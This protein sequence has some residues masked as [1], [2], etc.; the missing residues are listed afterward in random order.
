MRQI[1]VV[2]YYF[3]P[4]G[5]SGVQRIAGFVRRLPDYGWQPTVLT[6][7]PGGYYAYDDSLWSKVQDAAI[8]VEQ[9]RSLDPTRLFRS[10]TTVKFP[11]QSNQKVLGS[12][13]HWL[14]LPDNKVGWLPFAVRAGLRMGANQKFDAVL[15]SAPPYTGHLIGKMLSRKWN[16][17]LITDFR[18]DWVENPRHTYP[19]GIHRSLHVRLERQVLSHSSAVI[20]I[21]RPILD[22]INQRHP[23]IQTRGHVISH[24]YDQDRS[25]NERPVD[26]GQEL[27]F[28]YTGIFYDAQ[29]PEYF[30]RGLSKFLTDNPTMRGKTSAIFAGLVPNQFLHW[31]KT[32]NLND[33]VQYRGYLP[34]SSVVNL[35]KEADVLWMTI[36]NRSGSAGISTGKLFEYMGTQKP[37]LALVPAGTAR[38]T[39]DRYGAA[40]IADPEHEDEIAQVMNQIKG[41]WFSRSFPNPNDSFLSQFNRDQLTQKLSGILDSVI[42]SFDESSSVNGSKKT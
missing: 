25:L 19:T 13:S 38:E 14:F 30:L 37:I 39:L 27:K 12:I 34:H 17:P 36:G 7:K 9:T 18:D 33:V 26:P 6:A 31:V 41:D 5:L 16:V 2:A 1:L 24:G 40:Y 28:V 20:A 21:N 22:A 32:L 15:S 29:T 11:G 8:C 42:D 4:L 10:R 3:P 35:Q 23:G